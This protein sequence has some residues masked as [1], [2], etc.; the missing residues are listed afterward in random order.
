MTSE[1]QNW[2]AGRV[3]RFERRGAAA[4]RGRTPFAV[5]PSRRSPVK[6]LENY[7]YRD[8]D[9]EDHRH[10]MIANALAVAILLVLMCCG[11]WLAD[12]IAK[13][14]DMQDCALSGRSNCA[15]IHRPIASQW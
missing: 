3:L 11:L 14:R 1:D 15:P 6:D 2:G 7:V 12:T 4:L 10:R 8:E 9:A 13:M 5:P